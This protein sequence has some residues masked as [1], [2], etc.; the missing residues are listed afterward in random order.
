[1]VLD[2]T[3]EDAEKQMMGNVPLGRMGAIGEVAD[4]AA[5]LVSNE[6]SYITGQAINIGGGFLMEL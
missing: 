2:T 6:S 3:V 5:Y 4:L 1:V